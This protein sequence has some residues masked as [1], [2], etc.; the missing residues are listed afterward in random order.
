MVH[1]GV[2]RLESSQIQRQMAPMHIIS[3]G[4]G[5]F[6]RPSRRALLAWLG[7]L[8]L[9][10]PAC[11]GS[12]PV[13]ISHTPIP[14]ATGATGSFDVVEIDQAAHRLYVADRTDRGVAVFYISTAQ[15]KYVT[16]IPVPSSPNGLAIAPDL[17]RLFVGTETGSIAIIDVNPLSKTHDKV[18][19]EV[20]TGAKKADLL[21]YGADRQRLYVSSSTEGIVTSIDPATGVVKAH[22]TV[23]YAIEQPRYDPVD[24]MVYT[25]SPDANALFKIDPN[26]GTV[27]KIP[28]GGSC[29]PSGM[30]INPKTNTAV[31]A[32]RSFVVSWDLGNATAQTFTQVAGGDVVSYDANADRFLVA[33]PSSMLVGLYGG[34][35]VDYISS[36]TT[37]SKGNSAAYD[38]TND[39]V[40]T[41]DSRPNTVGIASFRPPATAPGWET[42]LVTIGP[43]ALGLVALVLLVFVT[44]GRNADPIRRQALA[45]EPRGKR[46]LD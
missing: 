11:G 35:P 30:A 43:F 32:C 12:P 25:T 45:L 27:T 22:F 20:T 9:G 44:V 23:G 31:I 40:Y 18:I 41:P 29:Q 19:N 33:S 26:D 5:R 28:L 8:S 7:M 36:V 14:T 10:M 4:R 13:A 34:N 1:L 6:T 42:S 2:C 37:G 38:E 21:D 3:R 24:G 15:P 16:T 17:G 46:R 39:M